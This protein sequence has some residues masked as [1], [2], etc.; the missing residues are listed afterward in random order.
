MRATDDGASFQ[1]RTHCEIVVRD[2]QR[3]LL[4]LPALDRN[5]ETTGKDLLAVTP[6]RE[7][8][9][10]TLDEHLAALRAQNTIS[11]DQP[12]LV[13]GLRNSLVNLRAPVIRGGR[14]YSLVDESPTR[15]A[16]PYFGLGCEEG[17]LR[18]DCALAGAGGPEQWPEFFCAAPPV[19]WDD[20]GE[21]ELFERMLTEFADHSHLFALPRGGHPLASDASRALW[22]RLQAVFAANVHSDRVTA[23]AALRAVLTALEQPLPRAEDYFHAMLGERREGDLVFLFAHGRPEELGR[24]LRL[25]GCRRALCVEN[26]GSIMPTF[27]PEGLNGEVIPLLRAPNFRPR[28]RALLVLVLADSRFATLPPLSQ[29]VGSFE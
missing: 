28:G 22:S 26:S 7:S 23:V 3:A 25:R 24:Q 1:V 13:V 9:K 8:G 11:P 10:Y 14:I 12:L 5:D 20:V 27:L 17:R 29:R 16:R 21:S 18:I 6:R 4:S 19:L 15:S 2:Y